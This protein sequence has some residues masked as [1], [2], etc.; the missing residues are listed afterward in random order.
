MERDLILSASLAAALHGAVLFGFNSN[1]SSRPAPVE[2]SFTCV[3][4]FPLMPAPEP[5]PPADSESPTAAAA[6]PRPDLSPPAQPDRPTVS[7]PNDFVVAPAPE[8]PAVLSNPSV[9]PDTGPRV[10]S[11]PGGKGPG[12]DILGIDGLDAT[13]R[14]RFQPSP[15]YPAEARHAGLP[16]EV[17]VEF[18]VDESGRVHDARVVRSNH[19]MFEEPTLR[20]VSRWVFEPG[21]RA[22]RAV[23]FRMAVPV[24]FSL[25]D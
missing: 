3:L 19:R 6:A 21:K 13:P 18:T 16:G 20:A 2:E 1:P 24:I 15:V 17:V 22:G 14:T 10:P 23:R 12:G 9:I 5:E 4:P 8:L 25:N 11:V 7:R